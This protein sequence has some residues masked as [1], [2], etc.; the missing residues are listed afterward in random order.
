MTYKSILRYQPWL[1]FININ[2]ISTRLM[3]YTKGDV[4]IAYN[5][6]TSNY[7]MHSLQSF[8]LTGYSNNCVIEKEFLNDWLYKDF[9]CNELKKFLLEVQSSRELKNHIYD[10][11]ESQRSLRLK[12]Q[13]KIIERAIGTKI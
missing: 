5:T 1:R 7:E 9:R 2:K 12:E 10:K 8:K 6:L 3:R 11:Q 4:F 13:L